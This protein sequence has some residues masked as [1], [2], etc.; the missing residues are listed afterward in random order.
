[1]DIISDCALAVVIST[2]LALFAVK[3][4]VISKKALW[5]SAFIGAA[6][7]LGGPCILIP[8]MLFLITSSIFT[9]AWSSHKEELGVAEDVKG[10]K[11]RQV[12][13]VGLIPAL[14]SLLSYASYV[15]GDF[16]LTKA[17]VLGAISSIAY[18]CADTWAS[19][20]GVLSK[21]RPRLIIKPWVKVNHGVS[22]GVTPL[23]EAI[24]ITAS[25][26]I[27]STFMAIAAITNLTFVSLRNFLLIFILGY[28]GEVLDSILGAIGQPKY[29]CTR[30]MMLCDREVH[31]CGEKAVLV[32]KGLGLKNED[33]NLI[34]SSL[35]A[36][37]TF[38]IAF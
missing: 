10:R 6:I 25:A 4:H 19:E 11:P 1:M 38:V 18:S 37:T 30:C 28:I 17:F 20:I 14:L 31:A 12:I 27:S 3:A 16:E 36:I 22:G 8:F 23:G 15:T 7:I 21:S 33:V 24:A 35:I 32:Y 9:K 2:V 29:Y 34:V 26:F 5:H 13:A